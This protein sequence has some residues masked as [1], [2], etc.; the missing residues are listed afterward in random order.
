MEYL[1]APTEPSSIKQLGEV[2]SLPE[3]HGVDILWID[4]ESCIGIQRKEINDLLASLQDGRLAQEINQITNS[5]L[6][7]HSFLLIEGTFKWTNTGALS[8]EYGSEFTIAQ[9]NGLLLSLAMSTILTVFSPGLHLTPHIISSLQTYLSKNQ[10]HSLLVRPKPKGKWG[11]PTSKEWSIHLLQ[12][13][14][15][16]GYDKAEKIIDHFGEIPLAWTVSEDELTKVDGIG[17][18]TAQ[19]LSKALPTI[20]L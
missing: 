5:N 3:K 4:E 18:V 19:R 13:F 7:T 16:I 20:T 9:L 1:I 8:K 2:S 14:Q 17:K 10:H 15:G 6:L 12:S 11:T